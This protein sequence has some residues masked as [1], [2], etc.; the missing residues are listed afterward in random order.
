MR[1]LEKITSWLRPQT[2]THT[3]IASE[4]LE[5][6]GPTATLGLADVEHLLTDVR[7][8]ANQNIEVPSELDRLVTPSQMLRMP[9]VATDSFRRRILSALD[10]SVVGSRIGLYALDPSVYLLV[11][12][13][14]YGTSD[15]EE[16][17]FSDDL[18]KATTALSTMDRNFLPLPWSM[19]RRFCND[20]DSNYRE[21]TQRHTDQFDSDTGIVFF[22]DTES[23]S[24]YAS[25]I[26]Q[27]QGFH[28]RIEDDEII[29]ISNERYTA[30]VEVENLLLEALARGQGP[31]AAVHGQVRSLQDAFREY[32][33]VVV[34]L[35]KR[36]D[37]I[38]FFLENHELIALRGTQR[39]KV[40]YRHLTN[41]AHKQQ[42][43]VDELLSQLTFDDVIALPLPLW[44]VI[45]ST[46]FAKARPDALA[47][48]RG[49]YL[50]SLASEQDG[51][52]VPLSN[53][54]D[55]IVDLIARLHRCLSIADDCVEKLS[56]QA[57]AFL[58]AVEKHPA[59][60]EMSI[61]NAIAFI[62][63]KIASLAV[64]PAALAESLSNFVEN[65]PSHVRAISRSE[66]S[67]L[68]VPIEAQLFNLSGILE[69]IAWLENDMMDE[70]S[71]P[72]TLDVVLRL[73]T[74]AKGNVSLKPVAL[75]AIHLR[76]RSLQCERTSP[77][78]SAYLRG[79]AFERLGRRDRAATHLERAF[80][81]DRNSGAAAL[82][83][84]RVLL[85][86]REVQRAISFLERA[87]VLT[88]N[89]AEAMHLLGA[90]RAAVGDV[91]GAEA[92]LSRAIQLEPD[93]IRALLTYGRN[94]CALHKFG[95]AKRAIERALKLEPDSALAHASMAVLYKSTGDEQLA[96]HHIREALSV[97]PDD[98]EVL[99][100]VEAIGEDAD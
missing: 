6:A 5:D 53:D 32:D 74:I 36:F 45:R 56:W 87:S 84:G 41:T 46:T 35:Q 42:C 18:D 3:P 78:E 7:R 89:D 40:D 58:I 51:R 81:L 28:T 22:I 10:N 91:E 48:E 44:R 11:I 57:S 30:K 14:T 77:A 97:S 68:L 85:A 93:D 39:L 72:L 70:P 62:G 63:D 94:A 31:Y 100:L 12:P 37:K 88:P 17:R 66:N 25:L 21:W 60:S 8:A 43:S 90:A 61:P 75:D 19:I 65:R 76:E 16:R 50:V 54:S 92:P 2:T 64:N 73:P 38:S 52:L 71:D 29:H 9:K 24:L 82:A 69:E 1:F 83:L 33:A 15:V 34:S 96:L 20:D 4:L 80:R 86:M 99:A 23:I 47:E 13:V 67:L 27:Q 59:F 95:E 49:G 26:A 55:N 79:L 98:D